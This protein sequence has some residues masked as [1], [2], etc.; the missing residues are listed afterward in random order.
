MQPAN[1]MMELNPLVQILDMSLSLLDGWF[2]NDKQERL[3]LIEEESFKNHTLMPLN[4]ES[5]DI[6]PVPLDADL[7]WIAKWPSCHTLRAPSHLSI[8]ATMC[9]P[10]HE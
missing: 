4:L 6:N 7:T 8:P 1:S 3:L 10:L 9:I 5:E 2:S